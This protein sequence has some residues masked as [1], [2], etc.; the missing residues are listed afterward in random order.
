MN[1][2]YI[3]KIVNTHGIKGEVRILSDFEYKE[4]AFKINNKLIV[5]NN[6]L[7]IKSYR[8][9]KNYDMIIFE[10]INDINDVLKYKGSDVY[11]DKDLLN[12]DGY[13]FDDLIGMEVY[14]IDN[15]YRGKVIDI[16]RLKKYD[17]LVVLNKKK[18]MIP[19][20]GVFV[21]EIK[22]GKIIINYIKGLEDED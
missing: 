4:E 1:L 19:Y 6:E 9:H 15:N 8:K 11:I 3:G 13:L 21:R 12:I 5:D 16:Y 7:I 10:G 14:D 18:Y 17:L 2:I 22:H 20:I